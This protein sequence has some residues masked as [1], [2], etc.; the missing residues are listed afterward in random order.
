MEERGYLMDRQRDLQE[1]FD[2]VVESNRKMA[3]DIIKDLAPINKGLQEINRN[4]EMKKPP[5]PKIASKRRL[6][7]DYRPFAEIFLQKYMDDSVDKTIGIRYENGHFMSEGKVM[8][9]RSDNI[10]ISGETYVGTSGMWSLI[11]DGI[12]KNTRWKIMSDT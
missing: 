2:P 3:Q 4:I 5:R 10:E 11:T 6:V 1:T 9:I 12:L 7:S 8:K